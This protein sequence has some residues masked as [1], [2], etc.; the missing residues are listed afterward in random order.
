[1]TQLTHTLYSMNLFLAL[2]ALRHWCVR[3]HRVALAFRARVS[4]TLGGSL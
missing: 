2:I 3:R 4:R 1:M